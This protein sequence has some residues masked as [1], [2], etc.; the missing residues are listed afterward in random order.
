[1]QE[2]IEAQQGR[3]AKAL[4]PEVEEQRRRVAEE[5]LQAKQAYEAKLAADSW[6]P[7]TGRLSGPTKSKIYGP[8]ALIINFRNFRDKIGKIRFWIFWIC[9]K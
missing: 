4:S 1:M 8:G 3:D 5:H 2:R 6:P 7:H 9:G